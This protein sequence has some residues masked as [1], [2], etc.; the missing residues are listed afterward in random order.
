METFVG[1]DF[2]HG[3]CSG[4]N[5]SVKPEWDQWLWAWIGNSRTVRIYVKFL[6]NEESLAINSQVFSLWVYRVSSFSAI[7]NEVAATL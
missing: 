5:R 2:L 1:K 7:N 3:P 6:Q 4:Y